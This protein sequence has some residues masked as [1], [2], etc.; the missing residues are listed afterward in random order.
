MDDPL[1]GFR[2]KQGTLVRTS[3]QWVESDPLPVV[4]HS[5]PQL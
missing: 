3:R 2:V 4:T 5:Y 1:K